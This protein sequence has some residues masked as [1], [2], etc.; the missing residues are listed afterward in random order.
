MNAAYHFPA[1]FEISSTVLQEFHGLSFEIPQLTPKDITYLV[2][3]IRENRQKYLFP[4]PVREIAKIIDTTYQKWQDPGFKYRR[5]AEEILPAISHYSPEMISYS[6]PRMLRNFCEECMLARLSSE[7][8]NLNVLDDFVRIG[9]DKKRAYG[10][11]VTTHISAGN[12][13]G[14]SLPSVV[15]ALLVKSASLIKTSAE[16]SVLPFLFVKSLAE[17]DERI[18]NC[19]AVC[20]WDRTDRE[21][22]DTALNSVDLVIAYGS[23]DTIRSLRSST[24]RRFIGYGH[25]V[26]FG[27]I[28]REAIDDVEQLAQKAALDVAAFD[29]KGCLSPHVYYVEEGGEHSPVE[30][31]RQLASAL[32][33]IQ[34]SLP[35]GALSPGEASQLHQV[36]GT[37][38]FQKIAGKSMEIWKSPGSVKWTVIYDEDKA[39]QLS[40][41]NRC[42]RIKP[43]EDITKIP[44]YL[45]SW[46]PYLQTAGTAVPDSRLMS[47]AEKL[48]Y[49]GVNRICPI[50]NMQSPGPGWYHDGYPSPGRMVKWLTI[51]KNTEHE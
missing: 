46:E 17:T 50:G 14:V 15:D 12:I 3:I 48:G 4:I 1:Q 49:I 42:I 19:L 6:I 8:G 43:V 9:S 33:D 28:S 44:G 2:H 30:F 40:C 11:A 51:E 34:N 38:E 7:L 5:A 21:L 10:P 27:V 25:K 13:P 37:V 26:S 18:S 16:D 41:L 23:D 22:M 39:F 31:A 20:W 32:E 35:T 24:N 29:Q 36:R 47:L 45:M